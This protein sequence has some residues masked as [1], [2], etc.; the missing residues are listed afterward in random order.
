MPLK[1]KRISRKA[2]LKALKAE[3][4]RVQREQIRALLRL[5]PDRRTNFLRQRIG[6]QSSCL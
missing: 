2:R 1:R 3:S 6:P 5:P 4:E